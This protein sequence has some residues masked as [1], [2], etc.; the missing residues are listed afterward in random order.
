M[1]KLKTPILGLQKLS[2]SVAIMV[3]NMREE[4]TEWTGLCWSDLCAKCLFE[5]K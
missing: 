5:I 2:A 1:G 4:D 3:T